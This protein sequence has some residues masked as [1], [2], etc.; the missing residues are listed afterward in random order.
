VDEE[1]RVSLVVQGRLA[2]G[3]AVSAADVRRMLGPSVGGE[4]SV[5]AGKAGVYLYVAT[6]DAAAAAEGVAREVLAQHCLSAD[7][8]VERWD[9]AGEAWL[10]DGATATGPPAG[11]ERNPGRRRWRAAGAVIMAIL[12]GI[13]A[14]G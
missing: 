1:W 14:S 13:G 5:S 2:G 4:V 11:Q 8:R 7:I 6:A 9:P 10:P 3:K 12:E